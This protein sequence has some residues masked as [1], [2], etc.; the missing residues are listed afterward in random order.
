[1]VVG[2]AQPHQRGHENSVAQP[3][4]SPADDFPQQH[5]IG[6]DW[7]VPAMLFQRGDGDENGGIF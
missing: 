2:I 6:E 1:V 7:H 3:F 4:V 5:A